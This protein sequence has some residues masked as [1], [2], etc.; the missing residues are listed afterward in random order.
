MKIKP[1]KA[2]RYD[3]QVVKDVGKCIA[4]P[5][6][7]IDASLR[8]RLY[9]QSPY[10]I[11]RVIQGKAASGDND[12][13]NVYTRAADHFNTWIQS[14]V[15]KQDE[16]D[17]LYGYVQDFEIAG[18]ALQ[19]QSFISLVELEPF[20]GSIKPHEKILKKPMEDRLQL[21]RATTARFGLVFMLY[22]DPDGVA[23]GAVQKACEREAL[24]DF[25]DEQGVRHRLYAIEDAADQAAITTMMGQRSC[26]IADGHHRYTTGLTLREECDLPTARFQMVAFAN[27]RQEGVIVLATHR[28]VHGIDAFAETALLDQLRGDFAL[29]AFTFV[30]QT[31]KETAKQ[32]MLEVLHQGLSEDR[33]VFGI[34]CGS[35]SFHLATLKDR[36]RMTDVAAEMSEAWQ[37]LDVAVLH[38]L[39]LEG[40]LGIDEEK[41]SSGRF[42]TYVKDTP[43]AIDD[44]IAQVDSGQQQAAFFTNPIKM[45]QLFAVTDTGERMPQKSTYF[46]PKMYTGLTIQKL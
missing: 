3:P 37:G 1:F 44:S 12:A 7:V 34:Y 27:T 24:V 16:K 11:V 35:R 30:D 19:R 45:E 25:T 9:E 23:E 5:Y 8:E 18:V 20:G 28:L 4:P 17:M 36:S 21:K 14:G 41:L 10:N 22:D 31:Q 40:Q 6:D 13:D 33:C 2:Y 39:I 43:T 15:L 38:K 32:R 46:Y 29:E 26:V 42:I